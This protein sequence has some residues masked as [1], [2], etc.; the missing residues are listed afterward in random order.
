MRG[1]WTGVYMMS[2]DSHPIIG[3]MDD[4]DGLFVMTGDSGSSFKTAPATGVC[5]AELMTEGEST[6]VDLTP[7]RPGRFAE[8]KPWVDEF[9]YGLAGS[10]VSISR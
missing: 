10:E 6:L 2:P 4:V 3:K 1:G 9:E 7:F 8:G 5:L